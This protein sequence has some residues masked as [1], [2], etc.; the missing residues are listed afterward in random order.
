MVLTIIVGLW[1]TTVARAQ[2]DS[3]PISKYSLT[4]AY[5][6]ETIT[7][8]GLSVGCEYGLYG[9]H[10]QKQR[11]K[12][13]LKTLDHAFVAGLHLAAFRHPRNHYG[14]IVYPTLGY[15]RTKTKGA[16]FQTGVSLGYMR[17]FLNGETYTVNLDGELKRRPLASRGA[18]LPGVYVGWGKDLSRT[19]GL[20]LIWYLK[21]SIMLQIPY[22]ATVLPRLALEVGFIYKCY[23]HKK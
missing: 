5:F 3:T 16:Y 4:M 8:Y 12:G 23:A 1:Q 10:K 13:T 21:P 7:H 11:S 22:N 9:W 14:V 6:G 15:A 17:V 19:I 20:P 18:F 2:T